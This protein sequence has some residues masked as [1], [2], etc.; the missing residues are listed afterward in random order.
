MINFMGGKKVVS[1]L[2]TS[3][4]KQIH[5]DNLHSASE[6]T[7]ELKAVHEKGKNIILSHGNKSF[8]LVVVTGQKLCAFFREMPGAVF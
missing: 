1:S 8:K 5:Q 2:L 7:F 6:A 3:L 4:Y